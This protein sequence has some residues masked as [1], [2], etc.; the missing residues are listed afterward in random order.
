MFGILAG[1][2]GAA[3]QR[4]ILLVFGDAK[5]PAAIV[6]VG[7]DA[8]A[9][10][11]IEREAAFLE[12]VPRGSRSIP[13]V[14]GQFEQPRLR[15][16]AMRFVDGES[17]RALDESAIPDLL[18]AWLHPHHTLAIGLTRT[19]WEL[20]K[21]CGVHPAFVALE[22]RLANRIV[23][24]AIFHGDFAPWNI[25]VSE[26]VWTVLDW[27]RGELNGLP[28]YDWFH[29]IIQ[30]RILVGKK[31]TTALV[32]ELSSLLGSTAFQQYATRA[33]IA[34]VERELVVAYLLHHN[35]VIRPG[36]GRVRGRKLF[37]ALAKKWLKIST[38]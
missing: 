38:R 24:P 18:T 25:K 26:G 33:G 23:H 20:E 11:L 4:F 19:W 8:E 2:P 16:L 3:G 1:N 30:T 17:P 28:G 37:N 10:K 32:Q 27:E 21:N 6:K 15:G 34:G 36:E 9:K 22:K 7:L 31:S 12:S 29:Y 35:E 14:R 13:A 5:T